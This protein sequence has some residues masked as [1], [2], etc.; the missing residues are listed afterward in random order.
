MPVP[1]GHAHRRNRSEPISPEHLAI[2]RER[3]ERERTGRASRSVGGKGHGLPLP[4][5]ARLRPAAS[6][7]SARLKLAL[8]L[9]A[10]LLLGCATVPHGGR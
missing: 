6:G 5:I 3:Q 9:G 4:S 2:I 8:A 7:R 1:D 10:A